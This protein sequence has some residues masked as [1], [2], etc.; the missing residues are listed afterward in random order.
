[1]ITVTT[2][3]Y[4]LSL[5][6]LPAPAGE[7]DVRDLVAILGPLQL[8]AAGVARQVADSART[9]QTENSLDA[10]GRLRFKST[11]RGS[12]VLEF[13]LGDP[14]T[15][16]DMPD[17]EVIGDRFE[18]L[19]VAIAMSEPPEWIG[20]SIAAACR[21]VSA[22]LRSCGASRFTLTRTDGTSR[23]VVVAATIAAGDLPAT[24]TQPA[25][26]GEIVGVPIEELPQ[27]DIDPDEIESFL[28]EIRG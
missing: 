19:V 17:E 6:D 21:Q 2:R 13:S 7:I 22:A 28:A 5:D 18:Q 10:A 1:M 25:I 20:P 11:K 14:D 16:P 4:E 15:L 26:A 8:V 3:V 12:T 27:I 9:D 23:R 24:W